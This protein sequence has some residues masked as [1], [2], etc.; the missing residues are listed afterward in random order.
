MPARR[1]KEQKIKR[2]TYID[3]GEWERP[4]PLGKDDSKLL[5]NSIGE[6][7]KKKKKKLKEFLSAI[8]YVNT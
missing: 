1:H 7:K 3:A 4:W 6:L 8:E 2:P 5:T